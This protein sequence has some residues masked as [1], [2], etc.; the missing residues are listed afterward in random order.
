MKEK[1]NETCN[2]RR[3]LYHPATSKS[4]S[5]YMKPCIHK[6][7]LKVQQFSEV[8]K[9][10]GVICHTILRKNPDEIAQFKYPCRKKKKKNNL[11]AA[12]WYLGEGETPG[13]MAHSHRPSLCFARPY[14]LE[15]GF[16]YLTRKRL[17]SSKCKI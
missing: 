16:I 9:M 6:N 11:T 3:I 10:N 15:R 7:L 12:C 5:R 17:I 1:K 8:H 14:A 4:T 2:A 13:A